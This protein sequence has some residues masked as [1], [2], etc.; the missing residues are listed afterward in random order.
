LL[1]D[2]GIGPE[3]V[4]LLEPTKEGTRVVRAADI[5]QVNLL[6]EGGATMAEAVLPRTAPQGAEQ[7]LLFGN[8]R[9]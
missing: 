7:L 6:L 1:T 9:A 5:D 8:D 2:E 3:E 4:L